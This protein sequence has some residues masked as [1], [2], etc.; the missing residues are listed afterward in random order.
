MNTEISEIIWTDISTGEI[1]YW[2]KI[3]QTII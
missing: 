1:E 3:I 2:M